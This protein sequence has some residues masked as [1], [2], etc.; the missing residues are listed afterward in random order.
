MLWL[1][2][3]IRRTLSAAQRKSYIAAVQCVQS[4]PSLFPPGQ[5]AGAKHLYDDFVAI[6]INQTVFI[7][8]SA[9]FLT[10]HRYFIHTYEEKL[11]A[12]GYE[13]QFPPPNQLGCL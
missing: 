9:T 4:T 5:V 6:H 8:L 13:G 1:T 12:C 10:W 7:H 3:D 2:R 11:A